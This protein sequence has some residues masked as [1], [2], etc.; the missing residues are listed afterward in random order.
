LKIDQ[1]FIMK[2]VAEP[3]AATVVRTI[4]SMSHHLGIKVTAEGV[5]T[6]DHLKVLSKRNCDVAQGYYFSRPVAAAGFVAA[7][8]AI[9]RLF[10]EHKVLREGL[11]SPADASLDRFDLDEDTKFVITEGQAVVPA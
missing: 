2:A 4:L 6:T 9:H 10:D 7:V 1:S 3:N 8:N 11:S 5:E